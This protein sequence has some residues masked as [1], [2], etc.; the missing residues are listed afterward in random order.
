MSFLSRG[1]CSY[2][3]SKEREIDERKSW[4]K[5]TS[6]QACPICN[7]KGTSWMGEVRDK[8]CSDTFLRWE[9]ARTDGLFINTLLMYSIS[10]LGLKNRLTERKFFAIP[11]IST[12][13][14]VQT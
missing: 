3:A 1:V 12:K 2:Y 7:K 10:F 8:I 5:G 14:G 11:S 6:D 9:H 4:K 13:E